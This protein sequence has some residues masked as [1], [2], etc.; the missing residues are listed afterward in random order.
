MRLPADAILPKSG[1][2]KSPLMCLT[3]AR[4]GISWGA[5]GAAMACLRGGARRTRRTA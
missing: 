5:I 2:I 1:G 4:Y 3:Q